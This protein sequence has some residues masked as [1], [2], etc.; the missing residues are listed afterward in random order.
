MWWGY[1]DTINACSG[2]VVTGVDCTA[3]APIGSAGLA[4]AGNRAAL[5]ARALARFK[6]AYRTVRD[7]AFLAYSATLCRCNA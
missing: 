3:D 1:A 2:G 4:H 6:K 5:S 7:A